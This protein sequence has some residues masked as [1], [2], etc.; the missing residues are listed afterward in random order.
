M[1]EPPS[2]DEY[3]SKRMEGLRG[4]ID[5]LKLKAD[6]IIKKQSGPSEV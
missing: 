1:I 5:K 3:I 2:T 6:S 4:D